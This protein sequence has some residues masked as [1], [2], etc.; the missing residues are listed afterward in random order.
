MDINT[1]PYVHTVMF[2][3]AKLHSDARIPQRNGVG[4]AGYDVFAV[5]DAVIDP[6]TWKG[7]GTGI[8][9]E[10]PSD[11]YA[12]VAPR[13]GLAFKKG[14]HV[15]AGV[16]DSSYRG[17]IRAILFNHGTVPVE[18]HKG[19]RIAQLIFE[20]IYTPDV[21]TEVPAEELTKS[22]RG[23]GGFGSSGV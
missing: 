3:V 23:Q 7:V 10:F 22:E 20:K 17:E 6:Q 19:D 15:L 8:T 13:S 4:D 9:L 12:R 11:C 14:V 5:E 21:L 2:R 1:T 16:V 18:I